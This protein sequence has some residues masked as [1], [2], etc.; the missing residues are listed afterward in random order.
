MYV[1]IYI[2]IYIYY[3]N[4]CMILENENKQINGNIILS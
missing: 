4:F 3:L 1:Y 2:Y